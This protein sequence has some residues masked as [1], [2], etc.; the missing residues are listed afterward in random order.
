MFEF[1]LRELLE[2]KTMVFDSN[3]NTGFPIEFL[4][5]IDH[6]RKYNN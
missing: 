2:Q 6:R 4:K 1:M 5:P 3:V